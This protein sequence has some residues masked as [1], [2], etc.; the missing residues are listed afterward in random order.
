MYST[1]V[2]CERGGGSEGDGVSDELLVF[3][4]MIS[5]PRPPPSF[6]QLPSLCLCNK[7]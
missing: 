3:S 6:E 4:V 1:L 5:V 7:K 2:D